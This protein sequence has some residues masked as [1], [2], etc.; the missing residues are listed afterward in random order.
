MWLF[1]FNF[2]LLLFMVPYSAL[3]FSKLFV[4]QAHD[5]FMLINKTKLRRL[6]PSMLVYDRAISFS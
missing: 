2:F 5:L 3:V 4:M 6:K 1:V